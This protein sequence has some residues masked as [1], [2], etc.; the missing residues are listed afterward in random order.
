MCRNDIK[1]KRRHAHREI[2][3]AEPSNSA[4]HLDLTPEKLA[5]AGRHQVL[6]DQGYLVTVSALFCNRL[7]FPLLGTPLLQSSALVGAPP[8]VFVLTRALIAALHKQKHGEGLGSI[9]CSDN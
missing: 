6:S 8:P 3:A 5:G 4:P 7:E 1:T 9:K 2:D